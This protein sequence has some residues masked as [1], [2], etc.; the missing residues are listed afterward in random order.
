MVCLISG[1]FIRCCV[2]FLAVHWSELNMKEKLFVCASWTPKATVQAAIGSI[3]LDTV[4][5][6]NPDNTELRE[7]GKY[8]C[9][10][11]R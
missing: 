3:A 1:M 8:A 7:Y 10:S 11:F 6:N 9:A 2:A 4:I 5:A